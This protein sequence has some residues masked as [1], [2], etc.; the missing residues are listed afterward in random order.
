MGCDIHII[1]ETKKNGK[2]NINKEEVFINPYYKEDG[3]YDWQKT[4]FQADP[5]GGRRYDWF[6]ILAD[7]RN[8]YGFAGISTGDGF[9]VIAQPKGLPD[10]LS[11]EGLMY[12]C[13]PVTN[14][15]ELE[16][17]EDDNGTYYVSEDSAN[18]WVNEY[19]C[20]FIEIDGQKYVTN[21]DYHSDSFITV[22]EFD[23][24]DWNQMT[25]KYGVISLEQY[26]TLKDT[27]EAPES[28]CGS[29]SG[30]DVVTV[31][32]EEADAILKDSDMLIE[33]RK[34]SE[35]SVNVEYEWPVQYREWF[36]HKIEGIVEPL[37]KLKERNEDAR[38]VFTFDN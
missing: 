6:S 12:F 9:D 3:E 26:K 29:T 18:R 31:S 25:M 36:A 2:W 32:Q 34:A 27:A 15:P 1:A 23:K 28:W 11:A 38:I 5:D 21:P 30:S 13:S 33:G 20:K 10:D 37:R 35:L 14:D 7:V 16:D 19:G 17:E 4:K 22:D 24:F 8:G